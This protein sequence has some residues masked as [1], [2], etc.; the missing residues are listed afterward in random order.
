MICQKRPCQR[1][2]TEVSRWK[3]R[4]LA[5][6]ELSTSF[7]LMTNSRGFDRSI[8]RLRAHQPRFRSCHEERW[9][10]W[11]HTKSL[12]NMAD[13]AS[14]GVLQVIFLIRFRQPAKR[15]RSRYRVA[16][17]SL[18]S[19]AIGRETKKYTQILRTLGSLDTALRTPK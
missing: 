2:L 16:V 9:K 15:F 7:V 1:R 13:S 8:L 18:G 3:S 14:I 19:E 17:V 12:Q 6:N 11:V 4:S 5:I 10:K